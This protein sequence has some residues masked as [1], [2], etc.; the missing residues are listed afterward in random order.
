MPHA[1]GTLLIEGWRHIPHS[2]A[3]VNSFQCL[4]MLGRP[5]LRL[6]HRDVPYYGDTWRP[7]SG[8]F[9][10]ES[11][12]RI[13]AIPA[14][15]PDEQPDAVLRMTAPYKCDPSGARRTL[16]FGTAE[17][18]CVPAHYIAGVRPLLTVMRESDAIL[19]TPSNWSRDGFLVSGADPDRVKYVP[20]GIDPKL[21]H[22]VPDER[23]AELRRQLGWDGF[24]FLSLGAMTGNK[25]MPLLFKAFARIAQ[26][27]PQ[28]RLFTKGLDALYPSHELLQ[29][30]LRD[31]TPAEIQ[32]I[33]P[34]LA[35]TGQTLTFAN[36]ARLYQAAD[37]YVSP[38]SA[39]GFNMPVLE[40]AACGLLSI[41]TCGGATDD[42]TRPE[43]SLQIESTARAVPQSSG[44]EGQELEPNFDHLVHLMNAAVE[45]PAIF[46]RARQ[47]GPAFVNAGFTWKHTVD[48][49]LELAFGP[50]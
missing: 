14:P 38:Y 28:V 48:Q 35:Y 25:G 6:L 40:A 8:L 43:F 33:H 31:L 16:V 7:I 13:A 24:V 20:H 26:R 49:L 41:C 10:P 27:H 39:E 30:Q 18:R 45:Q 15:A 50:G 9:D 11:E 5:G 1:S 22:P 2:Y 47:S 34:R 29:S 46:A 23:R 36:M 17:Y 44:A 19:V 12:A 32:I 3:V 42:F 37:T 21:Y 4:E